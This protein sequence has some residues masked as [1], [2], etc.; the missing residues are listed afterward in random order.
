MRPLAPEDR[1]VG[2][3]D[4]QAVDRSEEHEAEVKVEVRR[5]RPEVLGAQEC[6]Q[7]GQD[8]GGQHDDAHIDAALKVVT[9]PLDEAAVGQDPE[10]ADAAHLGPARHAPA[11]ELSVLVV[12]AGGRFVVRLRARVGLLHDR[13]LQGA[14]V[15]QE[16]LLRDHVLSWLCHFPEELLG[17][18]LIGLRAHHQGEELEQLV[19]VHHSTAILVDFDPLLFQLAGKGRAVVLL[20]PGATL[21]LLAFF[22][23]R[24][25]LRV[26]H[27]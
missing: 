25:V 3:E 13:V 26:L 11:H 7:D 20:G 9:P 15:L 4:G 8:D 18:L 12:R 5:G 19:L 17:D 10:L 14:E 22:R 16:V 2:A 27:P 21:W 6:V 1:P 23:S 24:L